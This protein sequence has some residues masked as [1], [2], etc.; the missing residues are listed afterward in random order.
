M[1]IIIIILIIFW[2]S[3]YFWIDFGEGVL[4]ELLLI[5]LKNFFKFT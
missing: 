4:I 5:R 2:Q 1:T 3:I